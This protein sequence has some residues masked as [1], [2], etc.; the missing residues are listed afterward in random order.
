MQNYSHFAGRYIPSFVQG[1]SNTDSKSR[2]LYCRFGFLNIFPVQHD[3][4]EIDPR[5][6]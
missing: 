4:Q 6:I 3:L 1:E 5:E 2:N